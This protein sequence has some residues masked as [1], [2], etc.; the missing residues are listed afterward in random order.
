[1]RAA[2]SAII[3]SLVGLVSIS[4]PADAAERVIFK[5][6]DASGDDRGPGTYSY[7]I[8]NDY[9]RGDLDLRRFEVIDEG[10]HIR[11]EITL[12]RVLRPLLE[13]RRSRA[14]IVPLQNELT[15]QNIDIYLQRPGT[16][17][18]ITEGLPGR[19]VAFDDAHG[20]TRA[21]VF[22][23]QPGY[24]RHLLAPWSHSNRVIMPRNL[25]SIGRKVWARIPVDALGGRPGPGWGFAVAVSGAL[26][27]NRFQF[28]RQDENPDVVN[29]FTVPVHVTPDWR[30]FGGGDLSGAHPNVLDILAEGAD[31]QRAILTSYEP[32]TGSLARLPMLRIPRL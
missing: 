6:N 13:P 32:K 21:V 18:R 11:F 17:D 31:S 2:G 1:M 20:W 19:Q 22:T 12:G 10:D 24:A 23:P 27:E 30:R 16:N 14:F 9:Q 26:W 25:Q 3:V 4:T 15:V 29:A 5:M 7:P 28:Y 8:R